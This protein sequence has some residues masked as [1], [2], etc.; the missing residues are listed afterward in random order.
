MG[1]L[2]LF[3]LVSKQAYR[4][5]FYVL[6][7]HPDILFREIA[8]IETKSCRILFTGKSLAPS[9]YTLEIISTMRRKVVLMPRIERILKS[10]GVN[11]KLARLRRQLK[12]EL[13]AERAGI[14]RTTLRAI[15]SGSGSVTFGAYA[16]VLYILG[17]GDDLFKLADDEILA[18]RF[19]E[20]G[21]TMKKRST[22]RKK[23]S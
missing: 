3:Q 19:R 18:A 20:I 17:F 15:E 1:S 2:F 16:Q 12:A 22:K 4:V 14:S 8:T 23:D 10:V 6:A 13:I 21:L 5:I 9:F 11:I 7:L